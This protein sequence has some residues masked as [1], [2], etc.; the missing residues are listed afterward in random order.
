M[1]S[2]IT[3][4]ERGDKRSDV[5]TPERGHCPPIRPTAILA[6]TMEVIDDLA[7]AG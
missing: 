7:N 3:V 1:S 2:L 6:H 5:G 4:G